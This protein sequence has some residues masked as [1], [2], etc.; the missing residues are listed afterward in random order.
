MT[1]FEINK[2]RF[3]PSE[4]IWEKADD[5]V[6]T[7][8][9]YGKV[10]VNIEYIVEAGLNL[11]IIPMNNLSEIC[12]IDAYLKSDFSGIVVDNKKYEDERYDK[13]LRFSIAHE[14]G[15]YIL[16][17]N[18]Y[19]DIDIG[20]AKDYYNFIMSIPEEVYRAYEY[21]ANQFAGRLLV[22]REKLVEEV[23]KISNIIIKK[24]AINIL[25]KDPLF[26]LERVTP[27]L[28]KPFG[29]SE[30]VIGRRVQEEKLWPPEDFK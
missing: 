12:G 6:K 16:H 22:P 24:D 23:K 26:V 10:P 29:V 28:C 7:Y 5:F 4:E 8:W 27:S 15:H 13:R 3:L 9:E 1:N 14:V 2:P 25:K 17:E 21:Q 18:F 30:D 19:Q 20:T 11:E